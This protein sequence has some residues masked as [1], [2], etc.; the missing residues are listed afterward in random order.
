MIESRDWIAVI[1][2]VGLAAAWTMFTTGLVVMLRGADALPYPARAIQE[3]AG[4]PGP[5]PPM[6]GLR[7]FA[8]IAFGLTFLGV[9]AV[10][11]LAILVDSNIQARPVERLVSITD[12][13]FMVGWLGFL[14]IGYRRDEVS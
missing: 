10:I 4:W 14:A 1:V 8:T 2:G 6:G 11:P 3:R 13:L 5:R 12:L 9:S 7:R